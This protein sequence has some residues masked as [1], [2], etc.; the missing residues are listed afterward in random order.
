MNRLFAAIAVF[1]AIFLTSADAKTP[2]RAAKSGGSSP[3][4]PAASDSSDPAAPKTESTAGEPA[5]GMGMAKPTVETPTAGKPKITISQCTVDGNYAAITFDDGP[6]AENTPR[7]LKILKER[8][9][10]A[11]FFVVGQCVAEYPSIA[12]LVVDEG[13]EIASHSWSHPQLTRMNEGSVTDQLQ[14]THDVIKQTTGVAPTLFRPPYGAFSTNQ[15][16]WAHHR[17]GYRTILWDVDT[18]DWKTRSAEK[19]KSSIINDTRPGSIILCH[20]I[21]KPTVDAIAPALDALLARGFK[22]VTV[23]TL[24][25][26]E[27]SRK[28][29]TS[30][31]APVVMKGTP[32]ESV[33][34]T[35]TTPVGEPTLAPKGEPSVPTSSVV[36]VATPAAVTKSGGPK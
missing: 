15:R 4:T 23:S 30:T 2:T 5:A 11:T 26:M 7:L 25:K 20:D 18:L 28:P 27:A 16:A 31:P 36:P 10:P 13:H 34:S 14:R 9:V 22:F 3:K 21:H 1:L 8:N 24:L 6:H 12:K 32:V 19:T 35:P 33:P 17:W 29:S